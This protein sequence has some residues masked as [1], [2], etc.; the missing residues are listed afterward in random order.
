MSL[1]TKHSSCQASAIQYS[2]PSSHLLFFLSRCPR[3]IYLFKFKLA[4]I[5]LKI[6]FLSHSLI[7]RA[8]PHVSS[9]YH[10]GQYKTD[11]FHS[12]R[13]FHWPAWTRHFVYIPKEDH[14][15]Q[16]A[17][18]M[19]AH[20]KKYKLCFNWLPLQLLQWESIPRWSKER[21]NCKCLQCSY[22]EAR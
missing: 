12:H 5:K 14:I 22:T 1:L 17:N 16:W 6:H 11:H 4:K 21:R 20:F 7:S 9:G 18:V 13:K 19:R 3:Y 15:F 10:I 2:S 8:Q